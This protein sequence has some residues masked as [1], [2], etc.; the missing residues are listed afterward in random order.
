MAAAN[1]ALHLTPSAAI[2]NGAKLRVET[3]WGPEDLGFWNNGI[4]CA[5]GRAHFPAAGT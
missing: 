3:Y 5:S 4:E 1:G 2:I